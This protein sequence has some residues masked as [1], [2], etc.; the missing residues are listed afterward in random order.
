MKALA[1]G[2]YTVYLESTSWSGLEFRSDATAV[3]NESATT[4]ADL[5]VRKA[6]H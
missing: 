3:V 6:R 2:T 5:Y 4:R 1:P